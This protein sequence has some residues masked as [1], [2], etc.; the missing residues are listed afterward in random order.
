MMNV[1]AVL[2]CILQINVFTHTR[3]VK[4]GAE[5][6]SILTLAAS[7]LISQALYYKLSMKIQIF[8]L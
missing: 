1:L 6:N 4:Q 7:K 5:M 2:E 8:N 3:N